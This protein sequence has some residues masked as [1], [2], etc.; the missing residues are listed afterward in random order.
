M[1]IE[2]VQSLRD[3]GAILQSVKIP[4]ELKTENLASEERKEL[5]QIFIIAAYRL[6]T[7]ASTS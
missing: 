2:V 6:L 4:P 1:Q 5:A 7:N 3:D